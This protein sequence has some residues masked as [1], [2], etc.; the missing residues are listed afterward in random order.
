MSDHVSHASRDC[1]GYNFPFS[2]LI[3]RDVGLN[4][5]IRY[6]RYRSLYFSKER[7]MRKKIKLDKGFLALLLVPEI[8]LIVA[9][10]VAGLIYV[11][12]LI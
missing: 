3:W 8:V 1:L 6:R 11:F 2:D 10:I 7:T 9:M 5:A 12:S 4:S